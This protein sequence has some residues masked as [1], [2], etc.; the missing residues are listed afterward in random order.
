MKKEFRTLS[1]NE[2]SERRYVFLYG[3]FEEFISGFPNFFAE[4]FNCDDRNSKQLLKIERF[5]CNDFLKAEL[6]QESLFDIGKVVYIIENILDTNYQALTERILT[7]QKNIFFLIAGDFRKSKQ[8][9]P[10]FTTHAQILAVPFFK[11]T[12]TYENIF[13]KF[14]NNVSK[15]ELCL[16]CQLA[17]DS[18]ENFFSFLKKIILL[19]SDDGDSEKNIKEY[20]AEN[21]NFLG[22]FENIS[23]LR[24]LS[25]SYMKDTKLAFFSKEQNFPQ[26]FKVKNLL[27]KCLKT[28]ISVKKTKDIRAS[29]ILNPLFFSE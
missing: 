16:L 15:E 27:E 29:D 10:A 8:V 13:K 1:R 18:T 14:L 19:K 20:Y 7:D 9:N 22:E 4:N 5:S 25:S 21:Q 11:N 23:L 6:Q 28:E 3:N 26:D 17:Q 24:F 2:I 12:I